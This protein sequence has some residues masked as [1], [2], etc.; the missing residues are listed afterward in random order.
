VNQEFSLKDAVKPAGTADLF[1]APAGLSLGSERANYFITQFYQYQL[2][3]SVYLL[4]TA[5][6]H[7]L[8]PPRR[9]ATDPLKKTANTRKMA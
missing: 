2:L 3:F 7:N 5:S 6:L 9:A 8:P 4:K 1:A